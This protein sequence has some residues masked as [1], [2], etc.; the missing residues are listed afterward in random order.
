MDVPQPAHWYLFIGQSCL[1]QQFVSVFL[2]RLDRI[3]RALGVAS[4][5]D[6]LSVALTRPAK[7]NAVIWPA[8]CSIHSVTKED[9]TNYVIRE[10]TAI[11]RREDNTTMDLKVTSFISKSQSVPR[12]VPL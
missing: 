1:T 5:A 7:E 11:M 10:A 4:I 9:S 2:V 3:A 12:W 8:I 6:R